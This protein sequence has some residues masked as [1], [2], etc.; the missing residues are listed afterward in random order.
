MS[1]LPMPTRGPVYVGG[2]AVSG[3]AAGLIRIEAPD[4]FLTSGKGFPDGGSTKSYDTCICYLN[5][6]PDDSET[7]AANRDLIAAAFNSATAATD[8]GFDPIAMVEQLPAM[9][10]LIQNLECDCREYKDGST[11]TCDRCKILAAARTRQEAP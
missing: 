9:L 3:L 6:H 2:S 7:V 10:L 11:E 4:S 5:G 8:M 1:E